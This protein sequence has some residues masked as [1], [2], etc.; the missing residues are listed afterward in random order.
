MFAGIYLVCILLSCG[1]RTRRAGSKCE[2]QESCIFFLGS[3]RSNHRF[4]GMS[5]AETVARAGKEA[6]DASQLL[7][8]SERTKA[9]SAIKRALTDAKVEILAANARDVQVSGLVV[10]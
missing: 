2:S 9:L 4:E 6:F 7:E 3:S 8:A 1:Q 10:T 5:S